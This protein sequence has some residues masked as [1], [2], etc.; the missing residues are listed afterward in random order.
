MTIQSNTSEAPA[1][2]TMNPQFPFPVRLTP[3]LVVSSDNTTTGGETNGPGNTMVCEP[4]EQV[5]VPAT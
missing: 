3:P 5:D 4:D 1:Q 2:E